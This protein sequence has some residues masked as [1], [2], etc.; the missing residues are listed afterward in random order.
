[1]HICD[2]I[3]LYYIKRSREKKHVVFKSFSSKN[4]AI[5]DLRKK[6]YNRI[7]RRLQY[8]TGIR[9]ACFIYKAADTHLEH[10]IFISF[11]LQHGYAE[12]PQPYFYT[13]IA[14]RFEIFIYFLSS[15]IWVF[16]FRDLNHNTTNTEE[17]V[18][19]LQSD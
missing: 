16:W 3:W 2:G 6:W 10:V 8:N 13:Y 1:M 5:Y 9:W 19:P 15:F 4:L 18:S 14:S 17:Q 12:A 11:P 7:G